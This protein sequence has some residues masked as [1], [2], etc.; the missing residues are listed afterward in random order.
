MIPLPVVDK[1][2]IKS[3]AFFWFDEPPPSNH[4]DEKITDTN[5]PTFQCVIRVVLLRRI[6]FRCLECENSLYRSYRSIVEFQATTWYR[7][8]VP[9]RLWQLLSIPAS[10]LHDSSRWENIVSHAAAA[11]C[12][13]RSDCTTLK[14][15][16][17]LVWQHD[18]TI[19]VVR[20]LSIRLP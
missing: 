12:L 13:D 10:T 14:N 18:I 15:N 19:L 4:V 3:I 2:R 20:L 9:I 6:R 1:V 11:Q 16:K 5:C 7:E 8:H 17:I